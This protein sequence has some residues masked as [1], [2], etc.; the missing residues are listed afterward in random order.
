MLNLYVDNMKGLNKLRR[1]SGKLSPLTK[2]TIG[3]ITSFVYRYNVLII[4]ALTIPYPSYAAL[5]V[6]KNCT[7]IVITIC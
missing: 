7:D 5:F 3:S 6:G 1:E 2:A 4:F